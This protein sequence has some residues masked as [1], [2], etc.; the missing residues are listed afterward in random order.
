MGLSRAYW[1][2]TVWALADDLPAGVIGLVCQGMA[3]FEPAN[4]LD[5]IQQQ[6]SLNRS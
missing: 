1:P 5:M 3:C 2:T 6:L 4:S